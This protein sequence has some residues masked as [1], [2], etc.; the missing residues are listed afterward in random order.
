MWEQGKQ[1]VNSTYRRHVFSDLRPYVCLEQACETPH[2]EYSRR[3][4]WFGHLAQAHWRVW[5]CPF[6]CAGEMTSADALEI[7]LVKTHSQSMHAD[8]IKKLVQMGGRKVA[9]VSEVMCPLCQEIMPSAKHYMRHVGRHQEDL[10]LFALPKIEVPDGHSQGQVESVVSEYSGFSSEESANLK[11]SGELNSE[12]E[13]LSAESHSYDGDEPTWQD[14]G[15]LRMPLPRQPTRQ[16]ADHI[17]MPLPR[18]RRNAI[19]VL[20]VSSF[21]SSSSRQDN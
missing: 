12:H 7:H 3:H 1:D 20:L 11:Q 5:A 17:R 6:N 18:R 15:R 14:E 2:E 21:V 13:Y 16:D 10:A 9:E 8:E 4:L 19:D